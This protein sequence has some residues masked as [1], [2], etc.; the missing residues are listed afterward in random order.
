MKKLIY[1]IVFCFAF[2]TS[3]TSLSAQGKPAKLPM[4]NKPSFEKFLKEVY[5]AYEKKDYKALKNNYYG[6]RAGE[7]GPDGVM[8]QGVKNLDASWK[9]F[10]AMVD[11][12]PT[13]TYQ[14][15]SSRMVDNDIA[16]ITWNSDSNIKVKGQQVGGKAIGMAVLKKKNESWIIEFDVLTPVMAIPAPPPAA[17]PE[18]K[19]EMPADTT[20]GK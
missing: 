3:T 8:I 2:S 7:I 12:K 10:D 5:D 15:T 13:F 18:K 6:G 14:L 11:E 1:F 19:M 17:M 9:A 16:V 20:G 4:E